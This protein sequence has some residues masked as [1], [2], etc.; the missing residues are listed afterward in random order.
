MAFEAAAGGDFESDPGLLNGV[1]VVDGEVGVIERELADLG[2]G[3]FGGVEAE[4]EGLEEVL[5]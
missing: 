5:V 2:A 4:G 1:G 3:L